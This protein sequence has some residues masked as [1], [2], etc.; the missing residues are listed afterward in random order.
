MK[1]NKV[2]LPSNHK[3]GFFFSAIFFCLFIY[4]YSTNSIVLGV[5]FGSLAAV[6]GLLTCIN[7]DTLAPFNR[8]WM[9][10]GI[11]LGMVISPIILALMFFALFTPIALI[12]RISGRDELKLRFDKKIS[13]WVDREPS[14]ETDPFVNQF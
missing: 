8:L 14:I 13:H 2:E 5:T 6:F 9:S 4:F 3:F 1:H 10:L 12:M 7:A 11:I